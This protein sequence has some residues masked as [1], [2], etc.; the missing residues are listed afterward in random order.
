MELTCSVRAYR[1]QSREPV[2]LLPELEH[3]STMAESEY[4]VKGIK[5]CSRCVSARELQGDRRIE[6]TCEQDYG[7]GNKI[8]HL[9]P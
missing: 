4:Q 2:S 8:E 9:R 5:I 1:E 7:K 3:R 6:G